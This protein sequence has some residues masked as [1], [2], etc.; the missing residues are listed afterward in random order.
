MIA[1]KTLDAINAALEA[2]QEREHR[3][4][5]GASIIGGPC[6]REVWYKWRWAKKEFFKGRMLRLFDR[7]HREETRFVEWLRLIGCTVWET[8]PDTG[9]QFRIS[10]H[11]GH[12]G[13]SCDAVAIGIPDLP[14]G[15][16]ALCEFKTHSAKWFKK[17]LTDGLCSA[18]PKHFAQCQT[19]MLKLGL[20]WCVYFAINKD[21]DELHP[22]IIQANPADG[23][24]HLA[25]A[26]EV[27][28][29]ETPPPR[30]SMK[31][32]WYQ[33]TFCHFR[34]IC[35]F[36]EAPEKNCRTCQHSKPIDAGQWLC[37]KYNYTLSKEEQ[38][39]GCTAHT[40]KPGI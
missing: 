36:G 8:D 12:F 30:V 37:S 26:G 9:E 22:E 4:H 31:P 11:A 14:P 29:S 7:G 20:V 13:G 39:Q 32:S 15:V 27:I 21:T 34:G 23:A 28:R 1:R 38:L 25:R 18:H 17:I 16:A 24:R 33:C 2:G 35:H 3:S 10:D 5:L 6:L 40:F 19:Y